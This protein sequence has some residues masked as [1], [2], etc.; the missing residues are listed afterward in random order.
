TPF[1]QR[2]GQ[3]FL[4]LTH[5]IADC[6]GD[7]VQLLRC[8]AKAAVA[9]NSIDHFKRIILPHFLPAKIMNALAKY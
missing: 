2:N 5:R 7:A 8:T 6:R 4:K 9:R 3:P 1:K